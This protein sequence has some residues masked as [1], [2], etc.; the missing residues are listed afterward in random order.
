MSLWHHWR[1]NEFAISW[2]ISIF[3]EI[4]KILKKKK[5]KAT[6]EVLNKFSE[7]RFW[8]AGLEPRLHVP[9]TSNPFLPTSWVR[10]FAYSISTFANQDADVD[11]EAWIWAL[12]KISQFLWKCIQKWKQEQGI[13]AIT[14]RYTYIFTSS[15]NLFDWGILGCTKLNSLTGTKNGWIRELGDSES[16]IQVDFLLME[17]LHGILTW[18]RSAVYK[19]YTTEFRISHSQD[20]I[21]WYN[22]TEDGQ[23]KVNKSSSKNNE[24]T[25]KTT[26]YAEIN[27][28]VEN[29]N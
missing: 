29:V 2:P 14:R 7:A 5:K 18:G 17:W 1:E 15:W 23:V 27:Y 19:Q 8:V 3:E 25:T 11:A 6:L 22:Y 16:W 12:P 21:N 24:N 9:L 20:G 28:T 4:L 10:I 26:R 13:S